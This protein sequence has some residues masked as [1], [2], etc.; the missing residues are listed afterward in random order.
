MFSDKD[1]P[2]DTSTIV[3]NRLCILKS[4]K[5]ASFYGYLSTLLQNRGNFGVQK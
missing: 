5:I 1:K 2:K 3:E 4:Q